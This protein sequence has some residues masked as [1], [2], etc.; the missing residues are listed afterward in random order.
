MVE[1]LIPL[2]IGFSIHVC[3]F[4]VCLYVCVCE[5]SQKFNKKFL[6]IM[7]RKKCINLGCVVKGDFDYV[8]TQLLEK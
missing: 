3:N 4:S 6:A 1:A 2:G 8:W 5:Y 7:E